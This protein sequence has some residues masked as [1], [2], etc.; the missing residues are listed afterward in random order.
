MVILRSQN[1]ITDFLMILAW[2][3]PF[4]SGPTGRLLG[5]SYHFGYRPTPRPTV[6]CKHAPVGPRCS[7]GA[8][9]GLDRNSVSSAGC[10]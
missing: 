8:H 5:K 10:Q 7:I 4:K 9:R 3:S 2:A 1:K 6:A